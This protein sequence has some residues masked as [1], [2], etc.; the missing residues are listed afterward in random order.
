MKFIILVFSFF[1]IIYQGKAQEV[2]VV[3]LKT[4]FPVDGVIIR[5]EK[6]GVLTNHDGKAN[7]NVFSDKE[8]L[9]FHHPSYETLRTDKIRISQRQFF[10]KL[11]EKPL[12]IEEVVVSV[13]RRPENRSEIPNRLILIGSENVMRYQPQ[14]SADLL[15]VNGEVFIQKSQQGGGSPMI[16]GFSANRLLLVVD[17]IR[18]NNAIFRSGNLQNVVS[19]DANMIENT[20][21]ILGPGSVIY[22]SDAV[23]G[24]L[25]FNTFGPRL[26]TGNRGYSEHSIKTGYAS[27][28]HAKTIHG[29]FAFG[30]QKWGFLLSGTFSDFDHLRMGKSGPDKYLRKEYVLPGFFAG[31]DSI[32]KNNNQRE[33]LFSGY[34]QINL[35]SKFRYLPNPRTDINLGFHYSTTGDVPRYDRLIV[36]RNNSLRYG[37][38]YYGPQQ[39]MMFSGKIDQTTNFLL[40]NRF[41][42]IIGYQ[43]FAESRNDRN[44]NSPMLYH[45]GETVDVNTTTIDFTK[46]ISRKTVVSYGFEFARNKINS[47]GTVKNL[48]TSEVA[49]IGTRYPDGSVYHTY[50][51]YLSGKINLTN[52]TILNSGIRFTVTH[53]DG[54]FDNRFYQLPFSEFS[55]N[56]QAVSGNIGL[57]WN[58]SGDWFVNLVA[59]SGFRSPNIDDIAK[60]FDSEPGNVVVPN[61]ALKPE[62]AYNLEARFTVP[63][64]GKG[65]AE[66]SIFNTW[67]IDAMVR[68]PFSFNG[69]DSMLYNGLMSRVE[70]L[71]NTDKARILGVSALLEYRI[72]SRIWFKNSFTL[73]RGEDSDGFALRHVPPAFGVSRLAYTNE[74]WNAE[75]NASYNGTIP[76]SRLSPD[77]RDK[78]YLYLL[79]ENGNPFSPKWWTLNFVSVWNMTESVR[80]SWGLENILNKRYRPY[81]SGIAAGG[82]SFILSGSINL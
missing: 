43:R 12:A 64:R 76:F 53:L 48:L 73:I 13:S 19:L 39:W 82:R 49:P 77:E 6:S 11:T 26:S 46:N 2:L 9:F 80:I 81:S 56:N 75:I 47:V 74:K 4:G 37:D 70:A 15:A 63:L 65:K 30:Q 67:L 20:E 21:V 58:P 23:G 52:N 25:S 55:S 10:V 62:Y 40:F 66:V 36:Y 7:L 14:T 50:A 51:A 16:R 29:R 44:I 8:I 5:S 3:D 57:I 27:A 24:V 60:V 33:Q 17:G 68:R 32:V 41:A 45:R 72:M 31:K 71:V 59:S 61:Q 78:P 54:K 79:N 35:M 69:Q 28:N 38:W 1:L 22:G 42:F 18:M 34:Q